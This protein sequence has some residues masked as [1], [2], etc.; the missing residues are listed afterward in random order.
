VAVWAWTVAGAPAKANPRTAARA[1]VRIVF[2][3][4]EGVYDGKIERK[5]HAFS[6]IFLAAT[7]RKEKSA[8]KCH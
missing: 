2:F 1:E 5:F 7:P 3:I 6:L 8:R 4:V